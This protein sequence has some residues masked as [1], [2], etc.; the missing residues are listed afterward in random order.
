MKHHPLKTPPVPEPQSAP[1]VENAP[2]VPSDNATTLPNE[3]VDRETQNMTPSQLDPS[4]PIENDGVPSSLEFAAL[5][6]RV[7][8]LEKEVFGRTPEN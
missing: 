8:L 1:P 4:P 7:E 3:A 2:T 5:R 6:I